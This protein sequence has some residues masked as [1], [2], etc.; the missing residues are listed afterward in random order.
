M[1]VAASMYMVKVI[2]YIIYISSKAHGRKTALDYIHKRSKLYLRAQKSS[3]HYI[4]LATLRM[5]TR[6]FLFPSIDAPYSP[7]L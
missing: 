1:E 4:H 3:L 7:L 6:Y 2:S 5:R